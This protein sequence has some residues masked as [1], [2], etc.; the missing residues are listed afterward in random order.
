MKQRDFTFHSITRL[1][2]LRRLLMLLLSA[3][4][5]KL[6]TII[7]LSFDSIPSQKMSKKYRKLI[8]HYKFPLRFVE[9]HDEDMIDL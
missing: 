3:C 6:V 2:Y 1:A 4:K 5:T 9:A 8:S 7:P